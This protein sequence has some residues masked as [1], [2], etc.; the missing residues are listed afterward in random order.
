[1]RCIVGFVLALALVASPLSVSAQGV[2]PLE[3]QTNEAAPLSSSAG[4]TPKGVEAPINYVRRARGGVIGSCIAVGAGAA[5]LAG[6]VLHSDDDGSLEDSLFGPNIAMMTFGALFTMGGLIG[7]AIS[8]G[9]LSDAKRQ[10]RQ[11]ERLRSR[12]M[13]WDLRTSRFVF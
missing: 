13:Q 10:L 4:D 2:D 9:N 7:A 8:G 11:E 1:M 6:S 12:R 5:L 3:V